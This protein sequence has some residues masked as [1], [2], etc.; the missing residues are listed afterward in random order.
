[1][2]DV[3]FVPVLFGPT[4][5][6]KTGVAVEISR[7]IPIE[8]ISA[9]SRQMIRGLDIGTAKPTAEELAQVPCHLIDIVEPGEK[10]SAYR[11][12]EDVDRLIP[13]I[14]GRGKIPFVV[15]GTGLYI[16]AL[17]DGVVE[18][19]ED[20]SGEVR[21]KLE[22]EY[23]ELGGEAL[24]QR[25][26]E[27]DPE[28]AERVHPHNRVRLVRALEIF[29]TTGKPKSTVLKE[30]TYKKSRYAFRLWCLNPV[31][32]ELYRRI[33]ERVDRMLTEGLREE[34]SE[35]VAE[36]KLEQIRGSG[37]IGY[38]ELI[39]FHEGRVSLGEAVSLIKQ[40]SRR[41]AKRQY[42]WMRHQFSGAEQCLTAEAAQ[43]A[44]ESA[45]SETGYRKNL[46]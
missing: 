12:I 14:L 30:S 38:N 26:S 27:V 45:L 37:V 16:R 35:L 21:D 25:L 18:L 46:T 24:H 29:V 20:E 7:S 28:E 15:G 41:Y 32:E 23:D 40:N 11:F 4:A 44:V 9:D 2:S 5:S 43:V 39:D 1:M 33:E 42:T 34:F 10:Y 6:G 22:S 13:E 36:G 31:R 19:E 8:V 17:L 3:P